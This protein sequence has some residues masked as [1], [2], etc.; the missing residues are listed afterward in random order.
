MAARSWQFQQ[1]QPPKAHGSLLTVL[2]PSRWIVEVKYDGDRRIAQFC[3][4]RL[5]RF[6]GT[7][8]SKKDG[9]MVEKTANLPHLNHHQGTLTGTVLDGELICT[10]SGARSKDVASIMGSNR[11]VAIEKQLERGW[12][13]YAVFDCLFYQ[14]EDL[15]A[16]PLQE[17]KKYV[18][19]AVRVWNVHTEYAWSVV[20]NP[21]ARA[22]KIYDEVLKSGGEGVIYKNLDAPYGD[23]RSWVKRKK[24]K[25]YDVV[26][27]GYDPGKGKYGLMVGAVKFGQYRAGKLL[28]CGQCSGMDD[29]MRTEL[30]RHPKRYLGTVME[31]TANDREE[32]GKFRHPQFSRLRP[33]KN[34]K[35]CIYNPEES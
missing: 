7:R 9:L 15:R 16:L 24:V 20:T 35:D 21:M 30:T 3:E 29:A 1:F 22:N 34:S 17:R 5:V 23:E 8:V 11:D 33:D 31:I 32:S 18:E 26:I 25:T 13:E 27:T 14:G 6:T 19:S 12:L 28:E 4:D 10:W 2:D